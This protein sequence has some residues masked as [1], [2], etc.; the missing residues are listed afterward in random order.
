MDRRRRMRSTAVRE[1]MNRRRLLLGL[2]LA[3]SAAAAAWAQLAPAPST[4]DFPAVRHAAGR[5][6]SAAGRVASA[7]AT[8][9]ARLPT[10][11]A[12]GKPQGELFGP[13]SWAPAPTPAAVARAARTEPEKP[14]APPLPYR[15]GGQVLQDGGMRV[16]LVKGD[17]VY[18]VHVGETL[19]DGYR[20]DAIEAHN[21]SFTYVPLGVKQ[22]LAVSG[23]GLDL[24]TRDVAVVPPRVEPAPAP[25]APAAQPIQKE[26]AN[27][28]TAQLR[29]EGPQQ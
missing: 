29:F 13:R 28:Q 23:P 12:M 15:L 18:E 16:V 1:R 24:P 20:L 4:S 11:E 27:L 2:A 3:A 6:A 10:R 5:D 25:A 21:L 26:A 8:R 19:D 9:L 22:Q 7:P 14:S 17:R